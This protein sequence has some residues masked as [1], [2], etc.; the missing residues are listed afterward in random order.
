MTEDERKKKI[1][2]NTD[3]FD[4]KLVRDVL[5]LLSGTDTVLY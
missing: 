3:L 2:Q 1:L 4:E 5:D